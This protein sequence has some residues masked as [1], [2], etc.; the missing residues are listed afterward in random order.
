[1]TAK[2]RNLLVAIDGSDASNRALDVAADMAKA[3]DG[4]LTIVNAAIGLSEAQK[5]EFKRIEGELADATDIL[6]ER[7]LKDAQQR[8]GWSGLPQS[9]I[10]AIFRWGE[11]ADIIIDC[12]VAEKV[13]AAV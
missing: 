8:A 2:L 9:R 6:A 4:T 13:D 1:M 5:A 3:A 12:I 11:P 10:N 7:A